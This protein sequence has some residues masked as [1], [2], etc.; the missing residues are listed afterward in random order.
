MHKLFSSPAIH[1]H[2]NNPILTKEDVPYPATLV[3]NCGV[4]RFQGRY[5][6]IFR[7]DYGFTPEKEWHKFQGISLGIAF[8]EDGIHWDVQRRLIL[9]ELKNEENIWA[10]DPRLTVIEGRAY[11]TFCLDTRHGMR[12]GIAVTD[13]FERFE[14]LSLSLPDLRNVVLFPDRIGG[15]YL[16]LERPF[17]IY[18]RRNWGQIDRFDMW[19]S[20]SPDLRYWGGTNLLLTVEQVPF[21]NEKIGPGAPPVKTERGWLVVY[22]AVDVDPTREASGWEL[23]W[24][25]RYTAG[26]MLLDLE[27]PR[28]IVGFSREPLIVPEADYETEE[29]F[30]NHVIFPTGMILERNGEVKIYYGAADTVICLATAQIDELLELCTPV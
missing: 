12:A 3:Y 23:T 29:N 6:M 7:N 22:H 24:R 8:S 4:T 20:V 15:K 25:K 5:V 1:R 26:I 28:K 21:A 2:P 16:R 11:M 18:L 17:P 13:D 14:V 10:Y 9:E 30:R 27:D 19:L